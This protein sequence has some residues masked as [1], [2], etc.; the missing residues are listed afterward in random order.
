M[1]R[2]LLLLAAVFCFSAAN[3]QKGEMGA[4]INLNVGLGY[5]GGYNNI[6][7]GAK[8]QYSF[9]DHIRVEPAFAY[10]FKKDYLSMWDVTANVHYVFRLVDNKLNLYP[11]A[12][13]GVTG[14]KAGVSN[15]YSAS[16]TK[17]EANVGGG[18]EYKVHKNIAIGAEFKY[19][20]ITYYSNFGIQI[21]ATYLF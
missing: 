3:A 2:F 4:G 19:R 21:G 14:I 1:K 8:Y 20:I 9:T 5:G 16:V 18:V 12:G 10:Y 7:I 17:F 6:G 11:L 15:L 13:I